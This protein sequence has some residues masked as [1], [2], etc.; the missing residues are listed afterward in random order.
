VRK[1]IQDLVQHID[2]ANA[3]EQYELGDEDLEE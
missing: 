3:E 1:Q 2:Q